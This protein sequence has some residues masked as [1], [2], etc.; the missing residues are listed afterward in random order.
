[1]K[2]QFRIIFGLVLLVVGALGIL[3]SLDI[4][5]FSIWSLWAY[6]YFGMGLV[7]EVGYF[8]GKRKSGGLLI[9]GGIFLVIGALF[10]LCTLYSWGLMYDLW[11]M[12]ILAPGFGF[13]QAYLIHKKSIG[14]LIP[15]AILLFIGLI[16]L[17]YT[18]F[19]YNNNLVI[20]IM[21]IIFGLMIVFKPNNQAKRIQPEQVEYNT[22]VNE[23]TQFNE[24]EVEVVDDDD[25]DDD[26]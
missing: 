15:A 7:F 19:G 24:A 10:I 20:S 23:T 3:A 11:P 25:S 2:G 17:N 8:S 5:Y 9:V 18:V 1:M 21:L 26:L 22:V 16:F 6:I 12:F 4:I 13:I 14:F